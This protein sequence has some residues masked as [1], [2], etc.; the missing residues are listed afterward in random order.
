MI[1]H[2]KFKG[3][4]PCQRLENTCRRARYASPR[5]W[6]VEPCHFAQLKGHRGS[7]NLD[8]PAHEQRLGWMLA[9]DRAAHRSD[10]PAY[11]TQQH[12]PAIDGAK[13]DPAAWATN[14]RQLGK[15]LGSIGEALDDLGTIDHIKLASLEGQPQQIPLRDRHP[16]AGSER[17]HGMDVIDAK[18]CPIGQ[19]RLPRKAV[20]AAC[21]KDQCSLGQLANELPEGRHLLPMGGGDYPVN[22]GQRIAVCAKSLSLVMTMP[23]VHGCG[24]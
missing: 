6:E 22:S 13:Y 23:L 18:G 7:R 14:A 10:Y 19:D 9:A 12:A 3:I 21:V 15:R 16:L 11:G 4:L 5:Q 20:A 2:D 1:L 8:R 17:T 24:G